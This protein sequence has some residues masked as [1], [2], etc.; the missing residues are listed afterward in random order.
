MF[1]VNEEEPHFNLYRQGLDLIPED[2][3]MARAVQDQEHEQVS[4]TIP[5]LQT[6]LRQEPIKE[7]EFLRDDP[8]GSFRGCMQESGLG[9]NI[10][11]AYLVA[12][13]AVINEDTRDTVCDFIRE[14]WKP[15]LSSIHN[16]RMLVTK[17]D[18]DWSQE[19]WT[20]TQDLLDGLSI[21]AIKAAARF[22]HNIFES[23]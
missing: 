15:L 12:W 16:A 3:W 13:N 2:T 14:H 17:N 5:S 22:F 23:A 8:E 11:V 7:L 10:V 9:A 18:A 6:R 21:E 1:A 19:S 20:E 4:L